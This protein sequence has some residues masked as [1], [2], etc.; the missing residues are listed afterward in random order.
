MIEINATGDTT[1]HTKGK[2]CD[3][4]ILVKVPAPKLQDKLVSENGTYQADSGYDGLGSVTVEVEA[5]ATMEDGFTVNFH[6]L[7]SNLIAKSMAKCG[8]YV[9]DLPNHVYDGWKGSDGKDFTSFPITAD[10]PKTIIDLYAWVDTSTNDDRLYEAFEIDK[11]I[12]PYVVIGFSYSSG[13]P[14]YY[15]DIGFL[16][17]YNIVT[18]NNRFYVTG[19]ACD[20][21]K[22]ISGWN[23]EI[24][25]NSDL[26]TQFVIDNK[27][28]FEFTEVTDS[29]SSFQKGYKYHTNFDLSS[30]DSGQTQYRLDE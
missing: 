7:D 30:W 3:D 19:K 16:K 6:D 1:L 18:G 2:Y 23:D 17:S 28:S 24:A 10:V 13:N 21:A 22:D 4:D 8:Y 11:A 29:V 14:N 20:P 9:G 12:Y 5:E 15:V 27:S 26:A 25:S